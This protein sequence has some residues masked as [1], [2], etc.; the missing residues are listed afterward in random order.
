[1]KR[2]MFAT[3]ALTLLAG[4][5][6]AGSCPTHMTKIDAALAKNPQLSVAEKAEVTKARADG[7]ASHKAGK[8]DESLATLAK[9]EKILK[10]M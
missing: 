2:L 6:L 10:I 1:M 3:V 7:E 5:A 9:A 4:P 8:H